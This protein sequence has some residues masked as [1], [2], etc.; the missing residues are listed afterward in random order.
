MGSGEEAEQEPKAN[1]PE[2][3]LPFEAEAL[4]FSAD[5]ARLVTG[6]FDRVVRVWD[7]A[8]RRE[9]RKVGKL[10]AFA[11]DD[12][13][14]IVDVESGQLVRVVTGSQDAKFSPTGG[15]L[16]TGD[17]G[18][19]NPITSLSFSRDGKAIAFSSMTWK[20]EGAG[21]FTPAGSRLVIA[22]AASGAEI[23]SIAVHTSFVSGLAFSPDGKTVVSAGDG[24]VKR[25]DEATS[26]LVALAGAEARC[27]EDAVRSAWPSGRPSA[28]R[29]WVRKG[30]RGPSPGSPPC[31]RFPRRSA[32]RSAS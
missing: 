24:V 31:S 17:K 6:G 19:V 32:P 7:V 25:W 2:P 9:L 3:A 15:L 21:R 22:D 23:R 20:A 1:S 30:D 11:T 12:K 27:G 5:G 29:R 4:A 16:A 26:D 28:H 8:S 13:V 14:S 10:I 18:H